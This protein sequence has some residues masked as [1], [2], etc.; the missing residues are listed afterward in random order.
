MVTTIQIN[1][2]TL[3]LLKRYKHQT[4][5]QTYDD[6]IRNF[7]SKGMGEYAK[8]FKGILK[9]KISRRELLK[10]LRDKKERY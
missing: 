6:V 4:N 3:E 8:K 10:D 5:V 1:D 9:I 2:D 7:M